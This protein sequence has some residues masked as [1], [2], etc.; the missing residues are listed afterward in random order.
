MNVLIF[1]IETVADVEAGRRLYG[2]RAA[3]DSLSDEEVARVIAHHHSQNALGIH[4]QINPHL[5]KIV[6]IAAVLRSGERLR[7]DSL[8]TLETGEAELL[9]Q[10]FKIIQHYS[11]TLVSWKGHWFAQPIL[12]YRAFLHGIYA[13]RYWEKQ[14]FHH[15]NPIHSTHHLDLMDVLAGH[16]STA[17]TQLEEV[18]RWLNLPYQAPLSSDLKWKFYSHGQVQTIRDSCEFNAL[19]IYLLLLRFELM[20]GNLT[21][22]KYLEE[23]QRIREKLTSATNKSHLNRFLT[24]EPNYMN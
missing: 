3:M 20:R 18:A 5:H 2:D 22:E 21:K 13:H 24:I 4:E 9:E 11:P 7:I 14:E 12:H 1:D 15:S 19:I 10:F 16:Q 6:A 23:Y 8:G 17:F